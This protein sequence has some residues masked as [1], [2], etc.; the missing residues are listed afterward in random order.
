MSNSVQHQVVLSDI[1]PIQTNVPPAATATPATLVQ[2]PTLVK[3]FV[4]TGYNLSAAAPAYPAFTAG[5]ATTS[6]IV[7]F[8]PISSLGPALGGT[9]AF[10]VTLSTPTVP[11]TVSNTAKITT[12]EI[13]SGTSASTSASGTVAPA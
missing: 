13:P 4:Y 8:A 11:T 6:P 5:T 12:F 1:L 2:L 7:T 10:D 9:I 3:N